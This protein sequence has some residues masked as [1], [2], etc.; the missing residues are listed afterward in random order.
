MK[1]LPQVTTLPEYMSKR[2]GGSRIR[3]FLAVLSIF[4]YIFT[5]ISVSIIQIFFS[6]CNCEIKFSVANNYESIFFHYLKVLTG[7]KSRNQPGC[8]KAY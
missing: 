2:F 3:V 6:L 1:L 4:L 5:K 8:K 7:E